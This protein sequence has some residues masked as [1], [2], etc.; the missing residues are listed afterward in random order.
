M[1]AEL[2]AGNRIKRLENYEAMEAIRIEISKRI[3]LEYSK[4]LKAYTDENEKLYVDEKSFFKEVQIILNSVDVSTKLKVVTQVGK[5]STV[6]NTY[7]G[8]IEKKI[9][10]R[11]TYFNFCCEERYDGK[12]FTI[13]FSCLVSIE[14][15]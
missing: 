4:E 14:I 7:E 5:G 9:G 12:P 3:Q 6:L 10:Y 1:K 2:N 11:D 15:L 13:G 8:H